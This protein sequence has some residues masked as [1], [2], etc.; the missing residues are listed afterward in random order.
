MRNKRDCNCNTFP[1]ISVSD[2]LHGFCMCELLRNVPLARV[3][4]DGPRM[5]HA[6]GDQ[7]GAHISVKLSHLDLVQIAV[8]PVQLPC[9]PVHSQAL[10]G[11]QSVLHHHFNPCHPWNNTITI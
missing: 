11:G 10:R 3:E 2:G 9:D 5:L 4:R 7:R 6:P 8:N 1:I